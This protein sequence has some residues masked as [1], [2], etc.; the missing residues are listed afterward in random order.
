MMKKDISK[1]SDEMG[2][3]NK[4]YDFMKELCFFHVT[5]AQFFTC[6]PKY[7]SIEQ[8]FDEFVSHFSCQDGPIKL[9]SYPQVSHTCWIKVTF[10]TKMGSLCKI[11]KLKTGGCD[12]YDREQNMCKHADYKIAI[13]IETIEIFEN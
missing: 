7:L 8:F 10:W 9:W 4:K 3:I 5:I 2:H 1:L 12:L 11:Y 6:F 13:Y